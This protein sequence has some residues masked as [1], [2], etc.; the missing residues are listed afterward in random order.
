MINF[1]KAFNRILI[2]GGSGFIGGTLVRR[3][4]KEKN[5][6]IFNIDKLGY[7]S[8]F[9][10]FNEKLYLDRYKVLKIDLS[11]F[12]DTKTAIKLINPDIVFHLAAESHVDRSISGPRKF[13]ESN[14]IG[15]FNLLEALRSHWELLSPTRKDFFRLIHISTDEVFGSLGPDGFFSEESPYNPSS[16]YSATKA[17]SDHLVKS[18]NRTYGIPIII[19]NSSNNFGPGQF[20][21]KFIPVIILNA[22]LSKPIPIFGDGKNIRDWLYVE[23][24][25]DALIKISLTGKVGDSYC[26]G[27]QKEK[28]NE[29]IVNV[30]CELLDREN[31]LNAPHNRFKI[32][33]KDR[34]GHDKRYAIDT[35]K[36][37]EEVNWVPK[38]DFLEALSF[39]VKWYLNNID[40][41]KKYLK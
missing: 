35:K 27:G 14:V 17:A 29:E 16:P 33:I 4:L 31:Y 37:K 6:K 25:I 22:L 5:L 38:H 40:W 28:S 2:T 41:C 21:E 32:Y 7:A 15:T 24:H 30:I 18:W 8:N 13:L 10:M 1:S 12:E 19:T 34:L 26:I 39:T 36:I 9:D 11:N 3:L 23:D 20:P